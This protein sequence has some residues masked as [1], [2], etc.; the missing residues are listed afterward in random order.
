M[1]WI[2][3]FVALDLDP[4]AREHFLLE[5]SPVVLVGRP[6][7]TLLVALV[8]QV[9]P[10]DQLLALVVTTTDLNRYHFHMML[11]QQVGYSVVPMGKRSAEVVPMHQAKK[12]VIPTAAALPHSQHPTHSR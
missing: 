8:E 6:V 11:V 3:A 2:Q 4:A 5:G 12:K 7:P 10:I 9:G 1:G